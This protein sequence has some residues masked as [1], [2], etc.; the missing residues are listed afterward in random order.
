MFVYKISILLTN[1][2]EIS[3]ACM[4]MYYFDDQQ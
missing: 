4:Y 2:I 1:E 3:T